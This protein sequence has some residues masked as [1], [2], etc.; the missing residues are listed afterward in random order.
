VLPPTKNIGAGSGCVNAAPKVAKEIPQSADE[1]PVE[2]W[3][4]P[5]TKDVADVENGSL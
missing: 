2:L 5:G 3:E 1:S 4:I